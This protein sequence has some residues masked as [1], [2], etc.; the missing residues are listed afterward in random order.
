MFVQELP[1]IMSKTY[2][3]PLIYLIF[4]LALGVL[5]SIFYLLVTYPIYG[6]DFYNIYYLTGRNLIE[7]KARL[8]EATG[9]DGF[10]N[11]AHLMYYWM[12]LALAPVAVANALHMLITSALLFGTT[13]LWREYARWDFLTVSLA[14]ANLHTV[15]QLLR[16]QVDALAVFG[17]ILAFAATKKQQPYL[18]G[19]GATLAMIKPTNMVLPLL[20]IAWHLLRHWHWREIAKAA[21]I[22]ILVFLS[23]LV[24]FDVGWPARYLW[25]INPALLPY[26]EFTKL[27]IWILAET[28]NLPQ[29][30]PTLIAGAFLIGVLK[31]RELTA[32]NFALAIVVS[33]IISSYVGGYHYV[34][35]IP[36]IMCI[37]SRK[38]VVFCWLL[39][40]FPLLRPISFNLSWLIM[41]YPIAICAALLWQAAQDE[42]IKASSPSL[43][44]SSE[45]L[46][47]ENQ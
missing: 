27:T 29:L 14:I 32:E 21:V 22:P 5:G 17:L 16:G 30:V 36:A 44:L 8:Y 3:R 39:S 2:P 43:V 40:L 33:Y 25:R 4:A 19:L 28:A 9:S 13:H 37:R 34:A 7:G 20:L 15:D 45:T 10:F 11:P 47:G 26:T 35:L 24:V 6:A 23:S 18:L 38:W 42:K 41:L 12:L 31:H 46:G 1:A